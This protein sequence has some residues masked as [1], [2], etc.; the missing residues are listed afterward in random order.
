MELSTNSV[1]AAAAVRQNFIPIASTGVSTA[2]TAIANFVTEP[3]D[4]TE[5]AKE[6]S[7]GILDSITGILS[8]AIEITPSMENL[9]LGYVSVELSGVDTQRIGQDG[10]G[11]AKTSRQQWRY[12]TQEP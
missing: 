3:V 1:T 9:N 4:E 11:I 7:I 2:W 12:L 5:A 6:E 8:N 10:I